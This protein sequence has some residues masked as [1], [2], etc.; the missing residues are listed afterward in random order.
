MFYRESIEDDDEFLIACSDDGI[1]WKYYILRADK[2]GSTGPF[3]DYSIIEP[4]GS[5][6]W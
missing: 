1:S 6:N 4:K 2:E 3:I 5:N